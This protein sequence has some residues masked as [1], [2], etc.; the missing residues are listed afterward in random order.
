MSPQPSRGCQRRRDARSI[1]V[2]R[3]MWRDSGFVQVWCD[4]NFLHQEWSVKTAQEGFQETAEIQFWKPSL[5]SVRSHKVTFTQ[6]LTPHIHTCMC[7]VDVAVFAPQIHNFHHLFQSNFTSY[8]HIFHPDFTHV[9][10][11]Y[12]LK[13]IFHDRGLLFLQ[14]KSELMI[15]WV[16]MWTLKMAWGSELQRLLFTQA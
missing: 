8:S 12:H 13:H 4:V 14:N 2:V 1:P 11:F 3:L 6:Q 16:Q 9:E 10:T 15:W 7:S 5:W